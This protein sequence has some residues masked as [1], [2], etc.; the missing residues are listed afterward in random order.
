MKWFWN[1]IIA[2]TSLG[3]LGIIAGILLVVFV[4]SYYSQDLPD[5]TELKNYE[6]PIVTRV[7]A[8]D[9]RLM[10]EYAQERRIF[11]PYPFIPEKVVQAFTAAEDKKFFEHEGV[12]ATAIVRAMITNIRNAGTNR[13]KIG[14]ST[15]TQQVAKNFLLTNERSYER[16]IRE[17]ILATRIEKALSKEKIMELY[18]NEIFLGQRAYGVA[19]AAL[20]YFNKALDELTYAEAAYLAALPK[21]PN[22]YHPIRNRESAIARRDWVLDRMVDDGHITKSQAEL[23]KATPLQ[24]KAPEAEERVE[25]PYFSEEI[26]R[27]LDE[28]YGPDS[29]YKG[30]LAV[31]TT[32]NPAMQ[33]IAQNVLREG[34]MNYDRRHGYRGPVAQFDSMDDWAT[35]LGNIQIQKGMLNN[36]RLAV[37]L[38][39]GTSKAQIA[40]A[41]KT[42]TDLKLNGVKWA[43]ECLQDCYALGPEITAVSQVLKVGDV[44]M[45][46]QTDD[47]YMLRQVPNVQGAIMAMNPHTGRVLAMQGGWSFDGSVFN[48]AT[49]ANRQPG[50]AF[51]PFVYL[52]ALDQGFTPA[53]LVLDAPFVIEQNPGQGDYW[54]PS[55]YSGNFYGPTPIRVGIEKS[56][57]LMTVRLADH[58]GMDKVVEYATRFGIADQMKPFLSYSLGAGET[59]LLRLTSAY[60]MLVNGGKKIDPTFID[61]IQDRYGETIFAHDSRPCANCGHL[62]RWDSQ[63][64]PD[65]TDDREQV[66]DPR[67]AYQIV[68]ILEGVVQ[69]GTA[70]RL[71]ELNRPMGGKTGTTNESKDTWFMG[72]TPDLVVGVFVGFDDPKSLGKKE[73]GSSV[74]APIFKEF[75]KQALADQPPVPFRRPS[76]IKQVRINAATGRAALPG[77]EKV[78]WES[79]VS[80]TEPNIDNYVL[81]TNV[82]SG[83]GLVDPYGPYQD[84]YGYNAFGYGDYISDDEAGEGG[85]NF[86]GQNIDDPNLGWRDGPYDPT[87][88]NPSQNLWRRDVGGAQQP[89]RQPAQTPQQPDD[90]FTGTGG[91]Y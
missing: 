3:F 78:I 65:V 58:I 37:V 15:I 35:K 85:L 2:L 1:T 69:R 63:K 64:T 6:P 73:T 43:R 51:K 90:T 60:A 59:T 44:I 83:G 66:A 50:S 18:L 81:D 40:F 7:Y 47:D 10:A 89:V 67:T 19:A 30:G 54:K 8:G 29:L 46:E 77:D 4:I 52:P 61:R 28:K 72:F 88:P 12:D 34:L 27:I 33:D 68:S 45:V 14:G 22:N 23:A 31:R 76:G 20:I 53:T 5:H 71:A 32:V 21:A 13:R 9:G 87:N 41:D 91:L 70:R 25:A 74:S 17:A 49:Q 55:N 62:I 39:A 16:K 86:P 48:R 38:D 36:W 56:R 80:G 42:K 57:N 26:R 82:I 24:M 75:I 79:F 11:V 84:P